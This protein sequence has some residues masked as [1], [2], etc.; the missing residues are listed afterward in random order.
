M[1]ETFAE[2]LARERGAGR[3]AVIQLVLREAWDLTRTGV[4][5]RRMK[6]RSTPLASRPGVSPPSHP[7]PGVAPP[8]RGSS[9]GRRG[10]RGSLTAALLDDLRLALRSTTRHPGFFALAALTLALGL[11]AA[12]AMYSALKAVVLNPLP[13]PE[14]ERLVLPVA[15]MGSGG[16]TIGFVNER[17]QV[18]AL[19]E[20]R[21]IFGEVEEFGW[22]TVT[23]TDGDEPKHVSVINV[24]P[25]LA[26][27]LGIRPVVGRMF[28]SDEVAGDGAR[29]LLLSHAFW[30]DRFGG[31]RDVLGRTVRA[32]GESWTVIGVMSARAASPDGDGRPVDLWLPLPES[33]WSRRPIARLAPGVSLEAAA[34][35][36]DAIVR[37]HPAQWWE[38]EGLP[39]GTFGGA[40]VPVLEPGPLHD[41]LRVLMIAVMLLL[42]VAC[43][44]VSN[45]L[46]E[47]AAERRTEIAVRAALG[48]GRLRIARQLL[49]ESLIL[50]VVGGLSGALLAWAGLRVLLALRPEQL[51]MLHN[52]RVDGVVLL[53]CLAAAAAAGV[54]F[55]LAPA[56]RGT[57]GTAITG[58]GRAAI[59]GTGTAS[60]RARWLLIG[61]EVALSFALLIGA[62]LVTRSLLD[63]ARRDPG[64][65]AD[66]LIAVN[67]DLPSW[68]YTQEAARAAA[69]DRMIEEMRRHPSVGSV[70][71]GS[72]PPR[73]GSKV[74]RVQLSGR[75]PDRNPTH[76]Y[77]G[78]VDTNFLTTIGQPLVAG[79]MFTPEDA[80][81]PLHPVIISESA[82]RRLFD[83]DALGRRFSWEG[84]HDFTVV[85]VVRDIHPAG[86]AVI[87]D[88]AQAC[89]PLRRTMER[90]TLVVRA[91]APSTRLLLD[92]Q[93]IVRRAEPDAVFEIAT[94][95][96][97][98]GASLARERFTTSLLATFAAL[99]LILAAV[100]L[101]GVLSRAV[102]ARTPEIGL[103][104]ALGA[105]APRIAALVMRTGVL[106]TS[107]GLIAGALLAGWGL[108]L[109]RSEV[110]GFADPRAECVRR[111]RR[112]TSRRLA[113]G[114]VPAGPPRREAR[115]VARDLGGLSFEP[116][117][118]LANA[119]SWGTA[120]RN[121]LDANFL[122]TDTCRAVRN[123]ATG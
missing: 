58:M 15:T 50:A 89:W 98:L 47:R 19:R 28:S 92:L 67:V 49:L 108:K 99:A 70:S 80:T 87:T 43:V 90:M 32:D 97:L 20:E 18:A 52:V 11:G 68:R 1:E 13:F 57:R 27:L 101:Y 114:D 91:D 56:V 75:T 78:D 45:L 109:L 95:R 46:L 39:T 104:M 10:D 37:S 42:L 41:H 6:R 94:V 74:G 122:P 73:M 88:D 31:D 55:G 81:S 100:G 4:T 72:V 33:D 51:E 112:H 26:S 23:L 53:F 38:A 82:A 9:R 62:A 65:R 86:L 54:I 61:T 120:G 59:R 103:R 96:E 14:A 115:S 85:G 40:V 3:R 113:P 102:T 29:V 110:F 71:L 117:A 30:R 7:H 83:G 93:R 66:E 21:G 63:L 116:F 35:R 111:R 107:A 25:G 24:T 8:R 118:E 48:A 22:G 77:G 105:D 79:R 121:V 36:V 16:P 44:N 64:Y 84:S 106:A 119:S 5:L 2:L 123:T 60:A 17:H 69:F 76:F 12:T 34:S